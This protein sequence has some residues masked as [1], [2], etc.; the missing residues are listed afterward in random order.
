MD[1][2]SFDVII[3][4]TGL[5]ESII[6][7]ALSKAGYK[8]AHIDTNSFYGGDEATLSLEELVQ[9]LDKTAESTH[10]TSRIQQVSRSAHVPSQSRQYSICL[11][12]SLIPSTGPLI[13]SLVASGVAKYS[14]FRLLDCVGIHDP[15]G[16]VKQ[17]PGSKGDIFKSKEISLV[18]KRRLMRFL[19][20]AAGEFEDKTELE[21]KQGVPFLEFLQTTFSL[22]EEI[23]SVITYALAFCA[24]PID[25]TLPTLLRLRTFLR[26]TG[27]Y[28]PSPFLIGHYGGIGDIAQGFCRAAAVSG[29]V[30]ILGR[31]IT[32]VISS[33][34]KATNTPA[35][36][37]KPS[38]R[39]TVELET[40]PDPLSCHMIISSPSY[41]PSHLK[42]RVRQLSP[43]PKAQTKSDVTSIARC[44]AII[45][46]PLSL[47]PLELN[48]EPI[49][50]SE[51]ETELDTDS[52]SPNTRK[53]VDTA[54]LIFPPSSVS[55]ASTSNSAT[56]LIT[57]E[58]SLSTPKGKW[59]VYIAL[60]LSSNPDHTCSPEMLLTPYLEA[61]LALSLDPTK[62][63]IKP[64]FT[65]FYLEIPVSTISS[66]LS[67]S[68][69]SVEPSTY[70]VPAPL[71]I[72]PLPDLADDA[73]YIAENAFTEAVKALRTLGIRNSGSVDEQGILEP[74]VFWPPLPADDD[75]EDSE[76]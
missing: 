21:G 68:S 48:T 65:A 26:S 42:D 7:A 62:S 38:F 16:R 3:F 60:P 52:A 76:W 46:R 41:V 1:E 34:P 71:Q 67:S 9:W 53:A 49:E 6:A 30:Y 24:S 19:T 15:T 23:A 45:D 69:E 47:R 2:N 54:V 5:V 37:G 22:N 64:L 59:L 61:L 12:P 28:G 70:L 33:H 72:R 74:I 11:Q 20:F 27:R 75:D 31:K 4:G 18:E 32:A 36:D 35:S 57:G 50:V 8:T 73:T 43:P 14:G 44:I 66:E 40:F 51:A 58:G 63:P 25:A 56:A 29:G 17:V 55:G 10:S 39:Y 13:A